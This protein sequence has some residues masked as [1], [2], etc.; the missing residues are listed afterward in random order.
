MTTGKKASRAAVLIPLHKQSMTASEEFSFK[1]TLTVLSQHD[2]FVICPQRLHDTFS[3]L[4]HGKGLHPVVESFP[5]SF[6]A[7]V[8]GY[9]HLLTSVDFYQRFGRYEYILIVQTDGL[10]F[11]DKLNQWCDRNYSYI[12][13]PWFKGL[14]RPSQPLAFLGVGNGGVSLRKVADFLM[15]LTSPEYS[16]PIKG[17]PPLHLSELPGLSGFIKKSLKFSFSFP[18]IRI[19]LNEDVFWGMVAPARC[20]LFKVP[21]P[22]DAVPFAFEAAPEYLFELNKYQLPFGCHAWERYNR[23]FW[24]DTLKQID[25]GLPEIPTGSRM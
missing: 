22:I 3:A 2:L 16:P 25:F 1:N 23:R 12:G 7:D 6:F 10:V 5:D 24:Q 8:S 17:R 20:N 11:A 14:T 21:A 18:P 13:A 15:V 9:N 4:R 19:I